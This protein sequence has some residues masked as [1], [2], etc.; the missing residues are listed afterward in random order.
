MMEEKLFYRITFKVDTDGTQP[1]FPMVETG[2]F[3]TP[4]EVRAKMGQTMAGVASLYFQFPDVFH[5]VVDTVVLKYELASDQK[6]L[7]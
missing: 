7:A 1:M 4:Q 3:K 5:C 2:E 6:M